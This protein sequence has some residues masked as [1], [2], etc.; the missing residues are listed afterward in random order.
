MEEQVEP[1]KCQKK[2]YE[3]EEAARFYGSTYFQRAYY[4]EECKCWH[5]SSKRVKNTDKEFHLG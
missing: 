4:C 1:K 2:R 3:S 5:L